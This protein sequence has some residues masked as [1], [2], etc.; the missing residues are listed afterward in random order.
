[1]TWTSSARFELA[2]PRRYNAPVDDAKCSRLVFD[3]GTLLLEAPANA[4]APPQFEWDAR[5]EKLRA[6]AIARRPAVQWFDKRGVTVDDSSSQARALDLKLRAAYKPHPYQKEALAAWV[7]AGKC[8]TVVLPTGAGKTFVALGAIK[9]VG[10]SALVVAPTIDLMSQWYS[11][12]VDSFGVDVGIL[13]GGYH[14]LR[15]LTVTTYDSAYIHAGDYGNRF[16]LAVFDEVHHLPSPKFQQIPVMSTAW[17]RLGLTATY[18]RQDGAHEML[19]FL[20]GPVVYRRGITDLKGDYLSD[21]DT[22][23]IRTSLSDCEAERYRA[24]ADCYFGFIKAT[25]LKPFGSGWAELIKMSAYDESARRALVAKQEMK[26]IVV[27]SERKL[28]VLDS[29]MKQH[30][31]DQVIVFTEHNDLVY[32]ISREFLIPAITHQT[33]ARERKWILDG[34]KDGTFRAIATSKVL[35]EGVDVP[36]AKIAI[37]LSGSASPRE[38]LQ[39]L[40]RILRKSGDRK[41][42][43]LYEVVT[44]ATTETNVSARRRK[45]DAYA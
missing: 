41:T 24:A 31:A 5:V 11:L 16:D 29:L 19:E 1:M 44:S 35:N 30:F 14:E 33:K 8:G 20:I 12:L 9:N 34:F 21:Y 22:V 17:C 7:E 3:G 10:R 45:T 32:R 39:R 26:R 27:G 37:V 6:P 40:G 42:A 28:E 38:H 43:V 4:D 25:G 18:E 36:S 15:D 23:R 13:G 2:S